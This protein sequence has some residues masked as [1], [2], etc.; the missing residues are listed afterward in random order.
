[1]TA[2]A[3]TASV[4][5]ARPRRLVRRHLWVVPGLAIAFYANSQAELHGLGLASLLI[6]GIVPH[7]PALFGSRAVALFNA[8]HHPLPPLALLLLAASGI[9]APVWFVGALAWLSHLVVDWALGD[10]VRSETGSRPDC[11]VP[12]TRR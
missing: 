3:R 9:V 11:N 6:F 5:T 4:V 7:V 10:G 12:A 1:M 2:S 8:M